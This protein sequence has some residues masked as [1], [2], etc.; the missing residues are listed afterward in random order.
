MLVLTVKYD[1][2]TPV[3]FLIK[4]IWVWMIVSQDFDQGS[5]KM[6]SHLPL[7]VRN[8][9]ANPFCGK[10]TCCLGGK[11]GWVSRPLKTIST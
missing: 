5:Q 8:F 6:Q 4:A 9:R 10:Y 7:W 2:E 11:C 3:C 1:F